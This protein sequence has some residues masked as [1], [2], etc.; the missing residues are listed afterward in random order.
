MCRACE[1]SSQMLKPE[2]QKTLMQASPGDDVRYGI[3]DVGRQ[4]AQVSG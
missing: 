4:G 3:S 2:N 1:Y